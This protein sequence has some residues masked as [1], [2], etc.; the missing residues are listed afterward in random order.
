MANILVYDTSSTPVPNIA[1]RYLRSR[2]TSEYRGLPGV[3][4]NPD[5][6][7][8][9]ELPPGREVSLEHLNLKVAGGKVVG[10]SQVDLGIIAQA[11]AAA[12]A[13]SEQERIA[14]AKAFARGIL[15]GDEGFE[16]FLKAQL[17]WLI[18]QI[19]PL[20]VIA[21]RPA[22]TAQTAKDGIKDEIV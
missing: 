22:I 12:D 17:T 13:A 10:L 20:N 6:P 15:D 7:Q 21:G 14:A 16:V 5:L 1:K 3:L 11:Q 8:G 4:I 19:N 2:N 18:K 9:L